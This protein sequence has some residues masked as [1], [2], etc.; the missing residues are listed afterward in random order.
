[1]LGIGHQMSTT[2]HPESQ[3]ERFHQTLKNMLRRYCVETGVM[4]FK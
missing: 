1:M 3:L 2:Y 4:Q